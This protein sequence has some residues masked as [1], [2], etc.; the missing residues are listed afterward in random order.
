MLGPAAFQESVK[1]TKAQP[2]K[3]AART[4]KDRNIEAEEWKEKM[5]SKRECLVT[6][7]YGQSYGLAC[8]GSVIQFYMCSKVIYFNSSISCVL[9]VLS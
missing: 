9:F 2:R 8:V 6:Y 4:K 3:P 7:N 1:A 5:R